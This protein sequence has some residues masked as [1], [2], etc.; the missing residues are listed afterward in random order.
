MYRVCCLVLGYRLT[1]LAHNSLFTYPGVICSVWDG[2]SSGRYSIAFIPQR[3]PSGA[4]LVAANR[5]FPSLVFE[6]LVLCVSAPLRSLYRYIELAVWIVQ[7]FQ[8][9]RGS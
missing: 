7:V 2:R 4:S 3:S 9:D 8:G 5:S 6:V 1:T